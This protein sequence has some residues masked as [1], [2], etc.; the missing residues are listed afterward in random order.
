[1]ACSCP[2]D[3]LC[4]KFITSSNLQRVSIKPLQPESPLGLGYVEE[5]YD[6]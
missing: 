1:M 5:L 6:T 3:G 2:L 4:Q